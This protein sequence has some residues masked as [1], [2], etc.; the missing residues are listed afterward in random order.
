MRLTIKTTALLAAAT[1]LAGVAASTASARADS[2]WVHNGSLM[3]LQAVGGSR[4]FV[5]EDPKPVLR[6]AGVTRGTLLFEGRR[7]GDRYEGTARRFSRFCR[8]HPLVYA[9]G[10]TVSDDQLQVKMWGTY[11]AHRQCAPTGE[12]KSDLLL[13]TYSHDC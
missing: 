8:A 12:T 2:C 11:D 13:F 7:V 10:G 1:L 9:V 6:R 3:R 5:Y 4:A